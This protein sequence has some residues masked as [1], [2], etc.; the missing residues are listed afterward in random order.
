MLRRRNSV[1]LRHSY[2]SRSC[3][4]YLN[5][6]PGVSVEWPVVTHEKGIRLE[7]REA[8]RKAGK[9]ERE[10]DVFFGDPL[11]ILLTHFFKTETH[12]TPSL[13]LNWL[14]I[15]CPRLS[16]C[17]GCSEYYP[18][19]FRLLEWRSRNIQ[20]R[21]LDV[22]L[23][24]T[25]FLNYFVVCGPNKD[26]MKCYHHEGVPGRL[27]PGVKPLPCSGTQKRCACVAGTAWTW[28][29]Y[30]VPYRDCVS[31]SHNPNVLVHSKEELVLVGISKGVIDL[32]QRKCIRSTFVTT[33]GAGI[34]R[35]IH[36]DERK[37]DN[38]WRWM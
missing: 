36:Y 33:R 11:L 21:R 29:E 30:C 28:D 10:R 31:R 34:S 25:L 16:E 19:S 20:L 18:S 6:L 37:M 24:G 22:A 1:V 5:E 12:F 14:V 35:M 13:L 27:C 17:N 26:K 23:I 32:Q 7:K 3:R 8:G 9:R 38:A 15:D 2:K 4:Y